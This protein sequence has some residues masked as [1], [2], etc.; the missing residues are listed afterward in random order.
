MLSDGE[1]FGYTTEQKINITQ[2]EGV[3]LDGDTLK[4]AM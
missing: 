3:N 4:L 2:S 1:T